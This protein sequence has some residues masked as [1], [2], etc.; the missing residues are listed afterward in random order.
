MTTQVGGVEAFGEFTF[1][2]PRIDS[3]SAKPFINITE[4]WMIRRLLKYLDLYEKLTDTWQPKNKPNWK[5]DKIKSVPLTVALLTTSQPFSW[6]DEGDDGKSIV[7]KV[8]V[9]PAA[10]A[11]R[12][13]SFKRVGASKR[14]QRVRTGKNK[15]KKKFLKKNKKIRP[16]KWSQELIRRETK[17]LSSTKRPFFSKSKTT[18]GILY[19]FQQIAFQPKITDTVPG[20]K[21]F[22]LTRKKFKY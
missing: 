16:R 10:G 4:A 7:R 6:L 2:Y 9:S 1:F 18:P 22:K 5:L 13:R 19:S 17:A 12:A 3:V 20:G 15:G 21:G 8:R 14:V 11:T